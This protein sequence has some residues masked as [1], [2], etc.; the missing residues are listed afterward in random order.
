MTILAC[1][2]DAQLW[3][4]LAEL[5]VRSLCFAISGARR[6]FWRMSVKELESIVSGLSP[7]EL[8]RFSEWFDEFMVDQWDRQIEQDMNA[9]RLDTALK[10]SDEHYEAGRCFAL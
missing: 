4:F 9:G 7:T 5:K 3:P 2:S 8:A 6:I 1:R 10:R